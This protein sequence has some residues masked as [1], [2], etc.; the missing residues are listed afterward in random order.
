MSDQIHGHEVMKM[1]ID[2]GVEYTPE[3]LAAAI[4]RKFGEGARFHTCSASN[5]TADEIVAFLDAK[6][7]FVEKG[8]GFTTVPD[9]ICKH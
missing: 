8:A 4:I 9:K 5:M 1:M 6:G 2:D 7:K 3:T